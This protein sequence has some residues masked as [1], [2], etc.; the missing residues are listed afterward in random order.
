MNQEQVQQV[1]LLVGPAGPG[2]A[3]SESSRIWRFADDA[4]W[5]LVLAADVCTLTVGPQYG[6]FD[7][8]ATRFQ[9]ILAALGQGAGV[10]RC[11]RLGL[12]YIDIAEVPPGDGQAWRDWF[13]PELT[14]W[15]AT[16]LVPADTQLLTSITQTQL[17]A[18]PIGE[19]SGP[20]ADIQGVIRHGYIPANTMVPGIFPLQPQNAAFLLDMDLFVEAPQPFVAD[21]LARQMTLLHDQIDRFFRWTLSSDGEAY[22]GLREL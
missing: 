2:S 5:A 13:R 9:T 16:A 6:S 7:D 18:R 4:G 3:E 14:G 21:E 15:S 19:L 10:S 12:R 17:A 1:S 22:F 11:E 20:P 8:F